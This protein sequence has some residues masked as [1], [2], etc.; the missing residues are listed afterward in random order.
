MASPDNKKRRR[1]SASDKDKENEKGSTDSLAQ[2]PARGGRAFALE[3][4]KAVDER[5]KKS[6]EEAERMNKE[7]EFKE[8]TLSTQ[9][10]CE[11]YT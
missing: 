3:V 1:M 7:L 11:Q 6:S 5:S 9:S 4:D 8:A 10:Q 2:L